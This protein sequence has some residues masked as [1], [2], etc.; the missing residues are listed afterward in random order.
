MD[1]DAAADPTPYSSADP[2]AVERAGAALGP[3]SVQILAV[4]ALSLRA[5]RKYSSSPVHCPATVPPLQLLAS[6]VIVPGWACSENTIAAWGSFFA[7]HGYLAMTIGT[8]SP[9]HDMPTARASALL[10]AVEALKEEHAR[11]GSP[12]AGRLDVSRFA[13]AGW[14]MGGG[15]CLLAALADPSLKCVLAFAPQ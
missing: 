12:V 9:F 8:H 1:L 11:S 13:V 7:S 15:G 6:I 14:S 4:E 5:N 10:D 2:L 3:H